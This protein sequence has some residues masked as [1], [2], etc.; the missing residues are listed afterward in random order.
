MGKGGGSKTTTSVPDYVERAGKKATVAADRIADIGY[1]PYYG[2]DVAAFAPQQ[3][4]A[5]QNTNDMAQAFGMGGGQVNMPQAQDF[6]G[7]QAYSSAP[8]YEDA[9][10]QLQ[11]KSPQQYQALTPNVMQQQAAPVQSNG[12][13]GKGGGR[14]TV[15]GPDG[16]T[17]EVMEERQN[18]HPVHGF[19]GGGR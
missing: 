18:Y 5:F 17:Y 6:N 19:Q 12:K 10:A 9:L 2:P 3:M 4:A 13:G 16:K 15:V 8:M 1:T 11:Q 14:Q 7:I